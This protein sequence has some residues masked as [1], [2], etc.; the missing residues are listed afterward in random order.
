[1]AQAPFFNSKQ[2]ATEWANRI[3]SRL[4]EI[5][6]PADEVEETRLII[7][8]F[9]KAAADELSKERMVSLPYTSTP[10]ELNAEQ[11]HEIIEL[12]LRGVNHV[13]KKLRS[14]GKS[15]ESRKPILENIAW[16]VFNLSKLLVGFLYVPNPSMRNLLKNQ[17]DL[18]LMMKQSADILLDEM[19]GRSS[20]KLPFM[21]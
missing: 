6:L 17:K 15:W 16:K 11:A 4:S 2:L 21:T 9:T 1:M 20:V 19:E 3:C 10:M 7:H 8:A 12:F 13:A 5:G 14:S 18:Q